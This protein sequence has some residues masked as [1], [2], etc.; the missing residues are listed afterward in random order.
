MFKKTSK[1]QPLGLFRKVCASIALGEILLD[2]QALHYG[3][4]HS[5]IFFLDKKNKIILS[6]EF[7]N[8]YRKM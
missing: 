1:V 5:L 2:L 3:E 4:T 7:Y 6:S 8:L